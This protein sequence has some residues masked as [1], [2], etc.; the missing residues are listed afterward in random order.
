MGK[1]HLPEGSQRHLGW[2]KEKSKY[3]I[4]DVFLS[5]CTKLSLV[6]LTILGWILQVQF[7][8][9]LLTDTLYSPLPP[10][11]RPAPDYD[12]DDDCAPPKTI[13]AVEVQDTKNGATHYWSLDKL[14]WV[15][16]LHLS[17][18]L[19]T[20]RGSLINHQFDWLFIISQR[21]ELM[22]LVYNEE[23]TETP[24]PT[25]SAAI[26][27]PPLLR[28]LS[29]CPPSPSRFS[30]S[31]L[32]PSRLVPSYLYQS[33]I[34][35]YSSFF[36]HCICFCIVLKLLAFFNNLSI[37]LLDFSFCFQYVCCIVMAPTSLFFI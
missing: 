7:Q 6:I 3:G 9:T 15:R 33:L 21:L 22:R 32:I 28:C 12:Q 17:V 37:Y 30:L 11:L 36:F 14:R 24:T 26:E 19:L 35:F 20:I 34:P 4:C 10:D 18:D 16:N 5:W 31:N 23:V 27:P 29:Q 1:C 25:P 8:F 13:V 2:V